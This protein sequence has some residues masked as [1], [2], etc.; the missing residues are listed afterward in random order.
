[1]RARRSFDLDATVEAPHVGA[2]VAIV[3]EGLVAA[4]P[5]DLNVMCTHD[6]S[7]LMPPDIESGMKYA[8]NTSSTTVNWLAAD[9]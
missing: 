9:A 5:G 1:V 8:Q 6:G 7:K 3:D 2:A 4:H